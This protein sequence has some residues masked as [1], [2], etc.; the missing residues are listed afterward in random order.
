MSHLF[1]V[2]WQCSFSDMALITLSGFPAAGKSTRAV[3]ICDFLSNKI[4]STD[5]NGPIKKI[6]VISD[7]SLAIS[8]SVYDGV[9]VC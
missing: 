1:N 8:R 3:Q 7:H 9:D 5:Y 4:L 2:V 6:L